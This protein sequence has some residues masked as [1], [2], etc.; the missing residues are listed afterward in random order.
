[1]E[2]DRPGAD[3]SSA[4]DDGRVEARIRIQELR[5]VLARLETLIALRNGELAEQEGRA[6]RRIFSGQTSLLNPGSRKMRAT[7]SVLV[8]GM[9]QLQCKLHRRGLF[10]LRLRRSLLESELGRVLATCPESE[11]N[12]TSAS[13]GDTPQSYDSL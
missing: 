2:Q 8:A 7:S 13:A 3:E 10:F 12:S 6:L 11:E 5:S 9:D 1:M 4:T